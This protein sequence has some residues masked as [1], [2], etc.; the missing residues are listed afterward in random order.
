[1]NQRQRLTIYSWRLFPA[2]WL[3]IGLLLATSILAAAETEKPVKPKVLIDFEDQQAFKL[4]PN[5]AQAGV[6]SVDGGHMLEITSEA[7]ASWPGVLIEARE[8]KWDLSGFDA[9]KMDISNPQD[10]AV[11][12]LLSINN[13]GAEDQRNNNT[14]SVTVPPHDKGVLV[15]PFGM[16][17]G[18]S[19]HPLD[20]KNIVSVKVLLDKPGRSH[21]FLVDNIRAVR[22]DRSEMQKIFTDPFF[23]QLKPAFGRGVN[24]GNALEAPKEGEW[25]VVLKEN[26][27]QQIAAAGF[28]SVRIPVRWS[29]HA[30]ESPPYS[31]D[32]KFF[33]RVDWAIDQS[34]KHNLIPVVNMHHYDGIFEDPDKH[35]ERFLGMWQQIAEHY[36]DY[37]PGVALELLNEPNGKLTAEKWNKILS[38]AV[39]VVRRSNPAREIVIGPA[40][41]NSIAELPNLKL[42]EKDQHLI[43]TV[44]YYSPFQFTHQGAEWT[45][46]EAKKWLGNKWTG[47]KAEQQAVVLDLDKAIAWAV[48]HQRP[49]YLGEFGAYNKADLE[50]RARWTAFVA[51][52]ALKHKM[53]FAYWEFC[54]GFGVYD[55]QKNQWIEP[56]K[57][58]LLGAGRDEKSDGN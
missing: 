22:F 19:G 28:N 2:V 31:I 57:Q 55:P 6:V 3:S 23:K 14:E 26:Y 24:L 11:R 1:M 43:V 10:E 47:T 36:K 12:V 58:A 52:E 30:D 38:E 7:A 29:A 53:G 48:E 50:S 45:G 25:G 27:F 20:L 49:L 32:P 17:H 16:W 56:L 39:K 18:T 41:W 35:S 51:D 46:A 54:S 33:D 34:L 44:H 8:G 42:P 37:P 21:R 4:H 40:G 13:P 9:V 5:E 15:V